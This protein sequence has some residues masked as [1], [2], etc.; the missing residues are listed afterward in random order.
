[1]GWLLLYADM[2]ICSMAHCDADWSRSHPPHQLSAAYCQRL[3]LDP[4]MYLRNSSV[5]RSRSMR[6]PAT[7]FT[8]QYQSFRPR[9]TRGFLL[10]CNPCQRHVNVW[11][12]AQKI[13]NGIND[14]ARRRALCHPEQF[15]DRDPCQ[16]S[17][18]PCRAT[19]RSIETKQV[20]RKP[21]ISCACKLQRS[22]TT[23]VL[24]IQLEPLGFAA[25]PQG[26]YV[27][28]EHD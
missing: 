11:R 1:I 5:V 15:A 28:L 4:L 8:E 23:N 21:F 7:N 10:V 22:P 27:S 20:R 6:P 25:P 3:S 13:F 19:R 14:T 26:G 9:I 24:S 12:V 16:P 18:D 2:D 17:S